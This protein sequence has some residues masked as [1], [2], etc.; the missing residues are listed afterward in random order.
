MDT[1][2]DQMNETILKMFDMITSL[3]DKIDNTESHPNDD[4]SDTFMARHLN[5]VQNEQHL[6]LPVQEQDSQIVYDTD[7]QV[8]QIQ[9]N[10]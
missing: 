10:S 7:D 9:N 6:T 2:Q 8:V 4:F 3:S 5:S 1:K